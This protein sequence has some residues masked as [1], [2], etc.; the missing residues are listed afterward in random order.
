MLRCLVTMIAVRSRKISIQAKT[1]PFASHY[2]SILRARTP[3]WE[4]NVLSTLPCC[5]VDVLRFIYDIREHRAMAQCYR[6][7]T[8]RLHASVIR[9]ASYDPDT[10]PL[11]ECLSN[12]IG[13]IHLH[14]VYYPPCIPTGTMLRRDHTERYVFI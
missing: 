10:E 6:L 9:R 12:I 11:P 4:A 13:P 1:N 3:A 2:R 8:A 5:R 7:D 14:W